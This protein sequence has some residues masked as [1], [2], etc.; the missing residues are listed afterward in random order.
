MEQLSS[1]HTIEAISEE[2]KQKYRRDF[3]KGQYDCIKLNPGGWTYRSAYLRVESKLYNFKVRLYV[4][5]ELLLN[6][7]LNKFN[8]N[9]LCNIY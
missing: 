6:T 7:N 8:T 4:K 1:G 5:S 3:E 2:T 9:K